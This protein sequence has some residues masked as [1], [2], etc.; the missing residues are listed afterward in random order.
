M[1][2]RTGHT[3]ASL[4]VFLLL[5]LY[6]VAEAAKASRVSLLVLDRKYGL[7]SLWLTAESL[8]TLAG[9][10]AMLGGWR[11]DAL[12][13]FAGYVLAHAACST[14]IL[15][16]VAREHFRGFFGKLDPREVRLALTYGIPVAG[17]G[18]LGWV[19]SYLDRYIFNATLGTAAT[20]VYAAT[21][22]IVARPYALS[23][24][25]LTNYFRP[26]YFRSDV[27]A[28]GSAGPRIVLRAW[29]FSALGIGI[30]GLLGFALFGG[31]VSRL[32]LAPEFR[33]NSHV[34]FVLLA[35]AQIFTIMTHALDNAILSMGNSR[36]LFQAQIITSG[37]TLILIPVGAWT[38]GILGG[39]VGR[40]VAEIVKFCVVLVITA[41]L[42]KCNETSDSGQINPRQEPQ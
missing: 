26:Q 36:R 17:M 4:V 18:P 13:F 8:I 20:G 28:A 16:V 14:F 1:A 37:V 32:A 30:A 25:V 6:V 34:L 7:Y 3:V 5:P 22:G 38:G 33:E 31:A 11:N 24:A 35:V 27:I 9:V 19:S 39:V 2:V 40:I 23:T 15:T 42:L 12:G 21:S 41:R 29:A 10:L